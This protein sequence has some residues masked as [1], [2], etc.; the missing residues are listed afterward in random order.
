VPILGTPYSDVEVTVAN[1]R[2]LD[3]SWAGILAGNGGPL[4]RMD[5]RVEYNS[6]E[7]SGEYGMIFFSEPGTVPTPGLDAGLGDT[8]SAGFNRIIGS[9]VG[10]VF[11]YGAE[12]SA[13]NNWWGS[14]S[15]PA[16]IEEANGGSVDTDPFLLEDP[17]K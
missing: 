3:S 8:G 12:V 4:D 1:N 7:N 15:G 2:I 14:A 17:D 13:G 6:I 11:S 10:D 9:G 16:H 5:L